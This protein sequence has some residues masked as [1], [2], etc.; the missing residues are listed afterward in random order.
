MSNKR[1]FGVPVKVIGIIILLRLLPVAGFVYGKVLLPQSQA[2]GETWMNSP[3][4]TFKESMANFDGAWYMRI[5]TIGYRGLKAGTYDYKK[6]QASMV[7]FDERG[8]EEGKLGWAYKFFPLYPGL[9]KIF[10]PFFSSHLLAALFISNIGAALFMVFIYR[11]AELEWGS[12]A[13]VKAMVCAGLYPGAF[14]LNAVYSEPLLLAMS[15]GA[16]FYARKSKWWLAGLLSG[17]ICSIRAEA[18]LGA[19]PVF[20]EFL[21]QKTSSL[22]TVGEEEGRSKFTW[23]TG[24]GSLKGIKIDK[25]ILNFLWIPVTLGTV[26]CFF[27]Y[28]SG[29]P[30][31]FHRSHTH[32]VNAAGRPYVQTIWGTITYGLSNSGIA[33]RGAVPFMLFAALTVAGLFNLRRSLVVFMLLYLIAFVFPVIDS[34]LRYTMV[35]YPIYLLLGKMFVDRNGL[36]GLYCGISGG[37]L[38]LFSAMFIQGYWI[39]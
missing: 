38:F 17:L 2:W 30:I 28:I 14:F 21:M 36:F 25:D 23:I 27:W 26:A 20:Y 4:I 24:L 15:T 29:D 3:D 31:I 39:A 34:A 10:K 18:A 5:A 32:I 8:Y 6:F 35:I 12:E 16:F 22:S 11:I 19:I 33:L 9:I 13:A 7:V 37:M 1:F